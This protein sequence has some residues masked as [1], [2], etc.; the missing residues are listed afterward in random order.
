MIGSAAH[1][2]PE[3]VVAAGELTEVLPAVAERHATALHALC[4]APTRSRAEGLARELEGLRRYVLRI[5][6]TLPE[7]P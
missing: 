1:R 3:H 2:R 7:S 4:V 6:S 5:A